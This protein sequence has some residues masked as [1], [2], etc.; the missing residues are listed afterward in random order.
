[1]SADVTFNRQK[2]Q[3]LP[4]LR[5]IC[6]RIAV[7]GHLCDRENTAGAGDVRRVLTALRIRATDGADR[8]RGSSRVVVVA[9]RRGGF[10]TLLEV[11]RSALF[12]AYFARAAS[13][14]GNN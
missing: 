14:V 9:D 8:R 11:A 1:M 2:L 13:L 3:S 12:R 10:A 7:V 4:S 5:D 6:R